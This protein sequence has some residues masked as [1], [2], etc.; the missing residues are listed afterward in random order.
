GV[1]AFL[2]RRVTGPV[3]RMQAIAQRM[4]AGDFEQRV[5]VAGG[6]E[7][8]ELGHALNRMALALRD[9]VQTLEA[10]RT[11]VAAILERMVEGVIALD[12]RGRILLMNPGARAIFDLRDGTA[13]RV[14][15]RPLLE[16]VR[17]KA[18][19]DLVEACRDAA[20]REGGRREVELGPPVNRILRAHAVP[21][22]FARQ[23]TGVVL[24]LHDVTELRRLERVRA[25]FVANVSHELRTP[26]T[27]IKG[28]LET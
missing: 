15:G 7:V 17:Q 14:A 26:L 19:F 18:L 28:Y 6:D 24:V 3:A 12:E 2:S 8:A 20:P 13:G 10:E 27:S 21:V 16:V 4:A 1:G 5:P 23:G 25:E 22:P 9:K 11:E